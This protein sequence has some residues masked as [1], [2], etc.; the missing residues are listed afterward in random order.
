MAA[1]MP[2]Q[3]QCL[4]VPSGPT[5]FHLHLIIYGP[6][7]VVNHGTVAQVAMVGVTS[8]KPGVPHDPACILQVGQHPFI[9]HASFLAYRHMRVDPAAHV[10]QM[11]AGGVW[12]PHSA[13]SQQLLQDA[14]AGVCAS[15]LTPRAMKT[16]FGCP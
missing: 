3:G 15:K 4:L 16:I 11:V 12:Q 14:I 9:Q 6:S 10:Q 5:G 2:A 13:C 8:I 1:W 7:V